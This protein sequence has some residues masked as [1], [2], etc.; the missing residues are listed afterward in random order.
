MACSA[1]LAILA[2]VVTAGHFVVVLV[3]PS[4]V[5]RLPRSRY[6]G[7]DLRVIYADGQGTL[8]DILAESSKLGFTIG[9]VLEVSSSDLDGSID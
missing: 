9:R 8:R 1:G 7:F 2:I 5:A 3:Y 6:V 4:L